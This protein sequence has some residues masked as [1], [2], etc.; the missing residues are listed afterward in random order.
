LVTP[1]ITSFSASFL[2]YIKKEAEK[3][4]N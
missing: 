1:F 3:V 2:I 4:N